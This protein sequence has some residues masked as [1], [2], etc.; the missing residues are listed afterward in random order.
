MEIGT[1]KLDYFEEYRGY[2]RIDYTLVE[3]NEDTNLL[4]NNNSSADQLLSICNS[5]KNNNNDEKE[6]R[7]MPKLLPNYNTLFDLKQIS[8]LA[9]CVLIKTMLLLV[10]ITT[11]P[12]KEILGITSAKKGNKKY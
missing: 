5:S 3:L 6:L 9:K 12:V 2:L 10:K 4:S 1:L 8:E 11:L 7:N